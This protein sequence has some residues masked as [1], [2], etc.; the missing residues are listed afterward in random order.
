MTTPPP[1][2]PMGMPMGNT[3]KNGLGTWALVLGI[4]SIVCCGFIAGVPAIILGIQSKKA[5]AEGLATNGNL[6]NIGFILG[7]IGTAWTVAAILNVAGVFGS[8]FL[9][10]TGN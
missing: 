6:G 3:S 8:A 7:I 9:S 2:P 1:P 10:S 4:L 5:A